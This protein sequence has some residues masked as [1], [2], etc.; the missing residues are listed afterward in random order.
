M[1]FET[2]AAPPG[3]AAVPV[4]RPEPRFAV[5]NAQE[6]DLDELARFEVGIAE[7][8]FGEDAVT[9]PAVHRERLREALHQ[10]P[11]GMFVAVDA[12]G[13]VLGWLWFAAKTNFVTGERYANFRS[14]AVAPVSDRDAI[15]EA[16]FARGLQH[17]DALGLTEI[18]G[19][20]HVDN[21]PMRVLYRRN[22]FTP[23]YLTVRR[24]LDA[25]SPGG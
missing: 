6:P 8:S 24:R 7:V 16:L 25:P 3:R 12:D 10:D 21:R 1:T 4:P 15:A 22:G 23:V 20:V 5:R 17:A 9:D 11:D 14:F 18:I 2:N 19:K 13:R